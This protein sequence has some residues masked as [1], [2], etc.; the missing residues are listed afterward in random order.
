MTNQKNNGTDEFFSVKY[1]KMLSFSLVAEALTGL[2]YHRP[3]G[4]KFLFG[5]T[6]ATTYSKYSLVYNW[7]KHH[8]TKFHDFFSY[9]SILHQSTLG[10]LPFCVRILQLSEQTDNY[11][12]IKEYYWLFEF[13]RS[14]ISYLISES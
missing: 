7:L 12:K 6:E 8:N 1:S 14:F 11:L 3:S 9:R 10:F 5:P 4:E 13:P 2:I